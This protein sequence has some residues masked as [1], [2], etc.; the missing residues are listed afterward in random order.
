MTLLSLVPN[1]ALG[2]GDPLQLSGD[3]PVHIQANQLYFDKL[4]DVAYAKG[5]VEIVQGNQIL[6]SD[7]ATFYRTEDIIYLKGNVAIKREDGSV[8]FSDEAKLAKSS[9]VGIA[10]NFK[11]RMGKKTL[12]ASKSA[13]L[14]DDNT[15]EMEDM[16]VSPCKICES[17][18]RSFFP[19]WQFRAKKAT[20]DKE[21]ERIYYKDAKIDVL[22]VPMFYTPYLSSPSPGAKRKSGFLFPELKHS[23][24][25]L[26]MG[27][28]VPLLLEHSAK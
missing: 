13:E 8:Y 16:V 15:M 6:I 25:T 18:Y 14:I 27:I 17:N 1:M 12:L 10:L 21:A 24:Q 23:S 26:G 22:G 19:L 11:A 28:K 3:Q 5:N 4:K 7:M 2:A 9:K 20:L